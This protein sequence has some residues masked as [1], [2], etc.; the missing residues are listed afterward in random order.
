MRNLDLSPLYRTIVGFDRVANLIETASRQDNAPNWPPYNIVQTSEDD[1]RIELAVAGFGEEDIDLEARN[2]LVIVKGEK[3]PGSEEQKYLHRGIAERSFE[4]HFQV[5]DHVKVTNA[6][7]VH[8]LLI[9]DLHR[10][11]PESA[12]PRKIA[13]NGHVANGAKNE[14]DLD[15]KQTAEIAA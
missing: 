3:K 4:R 13:I 2:D 9:I 10:E 8:G 15:A 14:L 5:A 7:L 1:Y 12:K 6:K 11:I